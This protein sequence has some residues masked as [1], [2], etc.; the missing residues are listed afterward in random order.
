MVDPEF[1]IGAKNRKT[2]NYGQSPDHPGLV[3][4]EVVGQS[5]FIKYSLVT[6]RLYISSL[7]LRQLTVNYVLLSPF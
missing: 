5:P 7:S 6:V 1:K 3:S 4:I 2:G